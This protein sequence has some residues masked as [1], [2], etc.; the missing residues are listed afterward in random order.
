MKSDMRKDILIRGVDEAIY[1]R[2]KASAAIK[3][4]TLGQ[5]V[6]QALASWTKDADTA[7]LENEVEANREFVRSNWKKLHQKNK[8]KTAVVAEGKLQ[9]IFRSYEEAALFSSNKFKVALVFM[10]DRPPAERE[11]DF[12]AELAV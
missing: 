8:G 7:N 4:I 2:A 9:G 3:G 1:R 11:I 12:G 10:V 5:A 6:D